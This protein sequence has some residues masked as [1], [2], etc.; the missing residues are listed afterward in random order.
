MTSVL[1]VD[2]S[3]ADLRRV[4]QLL[5]PDPGLEVWYAANGVEALAR[6]KDRPADLVVADLTMPKMGGLELVT[7]LR[8]D[9]P[10]VPVILITARGNEEIAVEA[11]ER[12]A[13]SYVPKRNLSDSL[14]DTV[15][16][17]LT[18]SQRERQKGELMGCLTDQRCAFV[19]EN[20][21]S[22]IHPLVAHLQEE[23]ARMGLRDE[24][25]RTRLGVALQVALTTAL[26]CGNLGVSPAIRDNDKQACEALAAQRCEQPPYRNRQVHVEAKLARDEAVFVVRDDGPGFDPAT[27]PDPRDPAS[28]EQTGGRGPLLMRSL[29][30]EVTYNETG[31]QVTLVKRWNPQSQPIDIEGPSCPP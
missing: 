15:R 1:V 18:L 23:V 6:M 10:L 19:L 29:M 27:R 28:L 8:Q 14:L 22:L 13:A 20:D 7:V 21:P 9:F 31:N 11:L 16:T 4:G 25:E 17:V 3:P 24:T 5:Q 2:D 26:Y 12:G 30:D